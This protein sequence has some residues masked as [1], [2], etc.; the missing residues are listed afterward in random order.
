[1]ER[2]VGEGWRIDARLID[3]RSDDPDPDAMA[4]KDRS[5]RGSVIEFKTLETSRVETVKRNIL[6][7]GKQ[8]R[9]VDGEV[10][11]DGR[12][13]E[14]SEAAAREAYRAAERQPGTTVATVE[15]GDES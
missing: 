5:D 2:L 14:L 10:V 11:V 9:S 15:Q 3:N 12:N 4:R 1:V 8:V 6:K 7:A 13:V